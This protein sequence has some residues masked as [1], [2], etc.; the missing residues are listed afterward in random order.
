[1][2]TFLGINID[3]IYWN[4]KIG[5]SHR[6]TDISQLR[7]N[8]NQYITSPVFFLSTGRCGTKWFSD[9]LKE[10][11]QLT[12]LH[13][14]VPSLAIQSKLVYEAINNLSNEQIRL[15]V[16]E[17]FFVAREQQLRFTYKAGK[18]Y[19]ETN[20]YI[21]FFA[22]TLSRIFPDAKFVHLYRHPGQFVR[23]GMRRNYYTPGNANDQKRIKDIV[24]P[25]LFNTYSQIEKI[26]WLWNETNLFIEKFK[27]Q[28]E[29]RVYTFNFNQLSVENVTNLMDFLNIDI[30]M[31]KI[32]KSL[33]V[34]KNVQRKGTVAEY[35]AWTIKEKNELK[36]QC[37]ELALKY[38]FKL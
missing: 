34:K 20:N 29:K 10:N 7:E 23:S 30:P 36:K 18:R 11:K 15:L 13:A 27:Q 1:M 25:E 5:R 38:G 4:L 35:E 31:K 9:L 16:Q 33:N 8:L 6:K 24:N 12:V 37:G 19:V 3:E 21:T 28:N 2:D 26:S 22:P 14:P 17:L 32:A